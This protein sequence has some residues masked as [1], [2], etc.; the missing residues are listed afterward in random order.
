MGYHLQWLPSLHNTVN[1]CTGG[2]DDQ[3][4]SQ[5]TVSSVVFVVLD[6]QTVLVH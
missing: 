6:A 3:L 1:V 4:N 5:E 2:T